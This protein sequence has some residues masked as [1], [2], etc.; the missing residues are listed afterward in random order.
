MIHKQDDEAKTVIESGL[1]FADK[2]SL[3]FNVIVDGFE[4]LP[5][6]ISGDQHVHNGIGLRHVYTEWIKTEFGMVCDVQVTLPSVGSFVSGTLMSVIEALE[7]P[8][9]FISARKKSLLDR[10]FLVETPGQIARTSKRPVMLVPHI[11][12]MDH[13]REHVQH[14]HPPLGY[15]ENSTTHVQALST[16]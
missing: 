12:D 4:Y 14:V 2:F 3:P 16:S 15:A 13:A 7:E 6:S 1:H 10:I 5:S 8:L 11:E 9:L